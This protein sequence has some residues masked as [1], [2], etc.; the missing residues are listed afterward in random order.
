MTKISM[1]VE[2]EASSSKVIFNQETTSENSS[3]NGLENP[4]IIV[5]GH[6]RNRHNYLQCSQLVILFIYGRGKDEY[7]TKE[8]LFQRRMIQISKPGSLRITW[9]YLE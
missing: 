3:H 5:T 7:L 9:W 2:K 4:S 1:V 8:S 6:K